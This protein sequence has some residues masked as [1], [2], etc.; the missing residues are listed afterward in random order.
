MRI[1]YDITAINARPSGVGTYAAALL[2]H[3]VEV[4]PGHEYLLLSNREANPALLP[5]APTVRLAQRRFPTRALWMQLSLPR[6]LRALQPDLCHYPNSLGPLFNPTPYV[7]NIFDMTLSLLPRY[8]TLRSQLLAR[9]LIPLVARRAERV[10]T[11]SE[12]ARQ[13]VIRVLRVAPERV[14][15]GAA[16]A[17]P[18]FRPVDP[19]EHARVRARYGLDRPYV[20]YVGTLE[21][22]KNLVRLIQAWDW[23]RERGEIQHQLALVGGRGWRDQAIFEAARAVG[24]PD[25]LVFAGYVPREDLPALYGAADLF[26][27]PSLS[28][29]FGLPV[30]EAMACGTPAL[31]EVA[32]DAALAADPLSVLALAEAMARIL[33]DQGLRET[34]RERGRRRAAGYSWRIAAEQTLD[35]YRSVLAAGRP[36]GD[37]AGDATAL[38]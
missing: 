21:P 7:V 1:G 6:R 9:P 2:R 12:H 37:A 13:D 25:D 27:F 31:V 10:I 22:R 29:G 17:A 23:L 28:E 30:V 8:H 3:L 24:R 18:M 26:A 19:A 32:G 33:N 5:A 36:L 4:E 20:L 14:V 11:L 34:L 15:V 38:S 35:L 16:A